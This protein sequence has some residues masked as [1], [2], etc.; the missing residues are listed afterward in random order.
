MRRG[1]FDRFQEIS[2]NFKRAEAHCHTAACW[3]HAR[4]SFLEG[5]R[6]NPRDAIAP[7]ILARMDELF[8]I[9]SEARR[10]ALSVAARHVQRQERAKPLVLEIRRQIEA[11]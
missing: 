1:P 10:R 7:P 5:V 9:D 3:A 11:A 6:L 8:A 4:R 2:R